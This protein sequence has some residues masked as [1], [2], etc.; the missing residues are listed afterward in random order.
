[1]ASPLPAAA[2]GAADIGTIEADVRQLVRRRLQKD[3]LVASGDPQPL[4]GRE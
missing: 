1:V 3:A 2:H 4:A